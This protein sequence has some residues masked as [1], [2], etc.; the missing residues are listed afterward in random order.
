[1]PRYIG[2]QCKMTLS[3][4]TSDIMVPRVRRPF[5]VALT[6]KTSHGTAVCLSEDP[7][8]GGRI[9]KP[10][11]RAAW[12]NEFASGGILGMLCKP[13]TGTSLGVQPVLS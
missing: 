7:T 10:Q 6:I 9:P 2:E 13:L 5:S 11:V 3:T 4:A 1:M 12:G 8:V